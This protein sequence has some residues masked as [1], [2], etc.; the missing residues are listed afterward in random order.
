MYKITVDGKTMVGCN[1]DAWRTTSRIWFEN[2]KNADEYG[3]GFTGS[4]QVGSNRTAPQSGMNEVGLTFSRLAAF[5]PIQDNAFPDRIKITDEEDYLTGILH[6]CATIED[7]KKYIAQY[8]H[9]LFFDHVFI[10]IDSTG[11]YL[12]VEPYQLIE[13]NEPNYLLSNFCPSITDNEQARKIERYRNGEDFLNTHDVNT[14]LSYCAALSDTMHVCR[15]RNGDGTLLTSIWD[16]KDKLVNLYFYHAY[17]TTVQFDLTEELAKGDRIIPIPGVFPKNSEFERFVNYRTPFNTPSLR[18]LLVALGGILTL[19]ALLFSI[20]ALSKHKGVSLKAVTLIAA[21]N[22]LLAAYLAVLA[23]H[24]SIYYFDAPY[25]DYGSN[26][27]S[28]SSYTPFLLL[29]TITPSAFFTIKRLKSVE[30]RIWIKAMLVSNNL[31]YLLL[32]VGFGYWGL[33]SI[34]N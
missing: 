31:I 15:C 34:W 20:S 17:D 10:Y 11:K 6:K 8:D 7:V 33:Y 22:L 1:E 30:I 12:I 16:T 32:I 25:K 29:L 2:A 18:I 28:V 5:Y 14:S 9:S 13:G 3:A 23:T 21:M 19:F 4:R 26:L 27:I 24:V